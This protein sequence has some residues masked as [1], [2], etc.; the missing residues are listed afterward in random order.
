MDELTRLLQAA[1]GGDE[2]ALSDFVRRTHADVWRFCAHLVD[3][4]A[5]D[6]LAQ[7]TY[8]RAMRSLPRYRGEAT[9]KTWLLAVARNTAIDEIR[10]RQRR[11]RPLPADERI[12]PD[13]AERV[14]LEDLVQLLDTDRR[15]A[16]FLTQVLQLPYDE[17]ALVCG[18]PVGTIRSR[19][20]RARAQLL[21]ALRLDQPVE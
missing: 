2:F 19:V 6:D 12:E 9:A 5:A 13:H 7:E 4:D 20:A 15:D 11:R 16:F 21:D 8:L 18:V 3:V 14:A 10:R 1:A 17:A